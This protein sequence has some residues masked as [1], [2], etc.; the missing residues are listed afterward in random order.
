MN[1]YKLT[2]QFDGTHF[3]GWQVQISDRTVQGDIEN[4]L[5]KLFQKKVT[6]IG[7]GRT[8][9]GVH[10]KAQI[11]NFKISTNIEPENIKNALN[12]N[13]K[14]DVFIENCEIVNDD[15]HSRF[16]AKERE[17][18]YIISTKYQLFERYY[19]WNIKYSLDIDK[20]NECAKYVMGEHDFESFCKA[21][22]E[23]DHKVCTVFQSEW[24]VKDSHLVYHVKAN[25]FLQHMV[26]YLVGTQIEV[27]RGRLTIEDFK[28]LIDN[29]HDNK[30]VF[31]APARGL[32]LKKI[33]Y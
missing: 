24:E 22:A 8:D 16:S 31:R 6:L 14:N 9:S 20:L 5:E 21:T 11:A 10:A 2:I 17:Y 29:V 32:F 27:A 13:L 4:A 1:N 28:L 18:E 12:A 7:S 19:T 15:F 23:V 3:H 33:K 25:R 26:R 30:F